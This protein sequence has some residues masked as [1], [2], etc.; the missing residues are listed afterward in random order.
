ML[1]LWFGVGV[2][3][4]MSAWM[5]STLKF[6]TPSRGNFIVLSAIEVGYFFVSSVIFIIF[7]QLSNQNICFH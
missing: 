4:A 3:V 2:A 7:A 6:K 5:K 1:P